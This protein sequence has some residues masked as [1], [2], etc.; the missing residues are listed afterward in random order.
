MIKLRTNYNLSDV[1]SIEIQAV[2]NNEYMAESLLKNFIGVTHVSP[3]GIVYHKSHKYE[4]LDTKSKALVMF[5]LYSNT[6]S[7]MDYI[8]IDENCA[9]VLDAVALELDVRGIKLEFP[10]YDN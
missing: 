3:G 10:E 1:Y 6:R 2:V 8:Y 7:S 9:N 4:P 5:N